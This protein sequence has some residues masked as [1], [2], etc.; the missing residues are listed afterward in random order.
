[1]ALPWGAPL[2]VD[3][4]R[5]IPD[6]GHRYELVDGV[7]LVTPAPGTAHQTCVAMLVVAFV[8]AAPATQLVLPAPYDWVVDPHT[9]FQPDVLVAHRVDV[10]EERL[11]RAPL[12]VVEVHSPS[13]RLADLTLKRAA[14]E[15]AGVPA[16]WLIDPAQP[17][18]TVLRLEE[19]RY[20]E[21]AKV[22]GDERYDAS[23][24][25]PV[26]IVPNALLGGRT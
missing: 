11:E 9:S 19:G 3:D 18:L 5:R 16:Y 20:V 13:T 12:L 8:A 23:W 4:L 14:Y 26:S 25:F 17:S 7:L 15:A 24:P 1:M 2:T 22:V 6:D 21:E 10:G